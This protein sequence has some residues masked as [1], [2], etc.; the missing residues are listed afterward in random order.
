MNL[1][2]MKLELVTAA[3]KKLKMVGGKDL[4]EK[5]LLLHKHFD[6]LPSSKLVN[7]TN[8]EANSTSDFTA[9]P[10]CGEEE[11]VDEGAQP[12]Q[13]PVVA[14]LKGEIVTQGEA[15]PEP[16]P[17]KILDSCVEKIR[18]LKQQA[19]IS[20]WDLASEVQR[21]HDAGLWKRRLRQDKKKS[22]YASW[23][24]FVQAELGMSHT[25]AY[26]LMKVSQT[27]GKKDVE[28]VGTTK[29]R[30]LVEVDDPK[31]RRKL[32]DKAKSGASQRELKRSVAEAKGKA[33]KEKPK[34]SVMVRTGSV[35]RFK[36]KGASGAQAKSL[37]ASAT[38]QHD[39]GVESRY[40]VRKGKAGL[41]I[42]ITRARV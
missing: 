35:V 14:A 42:L 41:E 29:L 12:E 32:L 1:K 9:C 19:A 22:L 36:L 37:P 8:C 17:D 39:N 3:M 23:K 33:S 24:D 34:E 4:K 5:A 6:A 7:C 28:A 40:E 27:F 10:F 18:E 11:V 26:S 21:C 31:V 13:A 38:E 2:K 16:V 25:H 15:V 20:I 30:L